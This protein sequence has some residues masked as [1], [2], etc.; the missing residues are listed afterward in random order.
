MVSHSHTGFKFP[1]AKDAPE[2]RSFCLPF[3]S[4]GMMTV[5]TTS[6]IHITLGIEPRVSCIEGKDSAY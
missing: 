3:L 6:L 1:V 2:F 4:A 5:C